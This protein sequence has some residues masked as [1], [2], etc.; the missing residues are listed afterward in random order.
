MVAPVTVPPFSASAVEEVCKVLAETVRG[1]QIPNL[2]ASL[3]VTEEP[4]DEQ[5]TKWKRLFNAVATR[6]N[7]M[8]DGRPL[9]RGGA[10]PAARVVPL[11]LVRGELPARRRQLQPHLPRSGQR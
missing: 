4:G 1:P 6:Q 2:I 9:I 10:P 7:A 3:L 11:A 5:N 8:K